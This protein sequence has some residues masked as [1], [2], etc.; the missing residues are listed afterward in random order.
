MPLTFSIG[1]VEYTANTLPVFPST[2]AKIALGFFATGYNADI[3]KFRVP[4]I[5]GH[6]IVRGGFYGRNLNISVRYIHE[7]IDLLEAAIK[8]DL[9][10]FES[11][12]QTIECH[13][14]IYSGC[15]ITSGSIRRPVVISPTG[16]LDGQVYS[17]LIMMFSEDAPVI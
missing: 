8:T 16:R 7:S 4:H 12:A 3:Y 5:D 14:Q 9:F 10:M 13:G 15:N 11:A 6:L 1:T 2:S 17:D